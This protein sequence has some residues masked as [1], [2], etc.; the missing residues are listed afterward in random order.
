MRQGLWGAT[1][2]E[3]LTDDAEHAVPVQENLVRASLRLS[4][5]NLFL[6]S[7]IQNFIIK[8]IA[9]IFF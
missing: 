4:K 2:N 7:G 5:G 9:V 1:Q 6:I 8:L 3:K